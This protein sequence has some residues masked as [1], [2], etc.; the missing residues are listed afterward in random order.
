MNVNAST[1]RFNYRTDGSNG[2]NLHGSKY[3]N[4]TLA[5]LT[6]AKATLLFSAQAIRIILNG[7]CIS[8]N[9]IS[10]INDRPVKPGPPCLRLTILLAINDTRQIVFSVSAFLPTIAAFQWK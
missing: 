4:K 9:A 6:A 1:D 8:N 2:T 5:G 7:I 10:Q 3:H